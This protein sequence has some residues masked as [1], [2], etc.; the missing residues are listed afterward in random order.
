MAIQI[1]SHS[2]EVLR[3][4]PCGDPADRE[5]WVY[6]PP[7]Y[8]ESDE[9]Y[10]VLWCLKGYTGSGAMA[11]TGNR[12][13]PGIPERVDR[14]IAGG[15]PPAIIAFPDCFTRWGGSQYMNSAATG[16][17]EDYICDELVP[18][19]EE[20]F[21]ATGRRGVFG[22]S[23]GGYGAVRL[24]MRRPGLF[25]AVACHSGDMGFALAYLPQFAD[26]VARLAEFDSLAAWVERFESDEK[27]SGADFCAVGT[28]ALASCYSP[29]PD[30]PFGFRFP[31]DLETGE[32]LPD[33]WRRW[34][35]NDLVHMVDAPQAAD[36]LRALDLLF[37][38][39]GDHDEWR[40]HLGLRLLRKRLDA[41]GIPH[42]AQEFPGTH[43][44]VSY[45][46]DVSIPKL[47]AALA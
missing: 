9:S 43:R 37:L 31:F 42:E 10:A 13:S 39:C 4:N 2:S 1:I 38:D 34:R 6:T 27:L 18:L 47:A 3:G 15:M 36:A 22:K 19:V 45:R 12:W 26:T 23:S 46:Y 40:H 25:H 35:E 7:G 11:C 5:L 33:I 30:A 21:R 29:D 28:I 44:S 41:L 17:Y 16:R 20:R 32:I 24:P 14:L 8:E